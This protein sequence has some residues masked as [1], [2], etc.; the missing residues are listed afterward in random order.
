MSD[1]HED[2]EFVEEQENTSS[3]KAKD[4]KKIGE[5]LKKCKAER[6][7]YLDGWQRAKA[8]FINTK[9]RLEEEGG[10]KFEYGFRSC[11]EQILPALDSL[12]SALAHEENEGVKLI[13]RQLLEGMG[14]EE[15]NPIGEPFNPNLHEPMGTVETD[16]KEEDDTIT[17]VL[18][19]GYKKGEEIIRPAKVQVATFN[20]K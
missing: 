12:E 13:K 6:Q 16:N 14:I 17:Q 18:Q 2:I 9:K 15:V 11:I 7:E 20:E 3:L 10:K 5:E 1:S 8:D 4:A 19:K